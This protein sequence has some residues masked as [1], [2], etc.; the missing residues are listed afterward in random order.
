MTA[1]LPTPGLKTPGEAHPEILYRLPT[2]SV[3]IATAFDG[4]LGIVLC[5][6]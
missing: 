6:L 3:R 2:I 1:Q 5:K 4:S